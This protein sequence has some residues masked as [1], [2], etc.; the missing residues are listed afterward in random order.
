MILLHTIS[1]WVAIALYA[2][3]VWSALHTLY[4]RRAD[5]DYRLGSI[6]AIVA[7]YILHVFRLRPVPRFRDRAQGRHF[8]YFG[9]YLS[10]VASVF[11]LLMVI[12]TKVWT[13]VALEQ[14]VGISMLWQ[15]H[16]ILGAS[17]AFVFHIMMLMRGPKWLS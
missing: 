17:G 11:G 3:T 8:G 5:G 10:L 9:V 7:A 4:D 1:V 16:H 6:G 14:G 15:V 13:S 12:I 2:L